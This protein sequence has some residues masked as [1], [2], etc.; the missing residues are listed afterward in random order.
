LSKVLVLGCNS[1]AGSVFVDSALTAG[2]DVVGIN[3]SG[4]GS[5]NFLPY[6][7][8]ARVKNYKFHQLHLVN[9]LEQ[10]ISVIGDCE[11]EYIVDFAGQGMVAESWEAP[12]LWYETNLVSKVRLHDFLRKCRF[13]KQYI[14]V[15]TPEVY[16]SNTGLISESCGYNPSTPYAVSHAAVDMSLLAFYRNYGFPAVITRFA[17]FYGPGQ[18]LY[19]IIPKTV[20]TALSSGV[21]NLHGGGS[22]IR[23]FI[24]ASDIASALLLTLQ[25]GEPGE[26]YHFTTDEFLTIREVVERIL[27]R[28]DID[29]DSCVKITS[30]RLGKDQAY[31]MD[32]SKAKKALGWQP[33]V[34][35]DRGVDSTISWVREGITE[36]MDLPHEYKHKS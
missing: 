29:F 35:F 26:V 27:R 8:N 5:M 10:I 13:L 11:P 25:K 23:A 30:D 18:Q 14:R 31:L 32:S 4:E 24:Y 2:F 33:L 7:R 19:R 21:L 12:E 28:L 17:N 22:S 20:L 16:G 3:R 15:S 34:S 1:F 6:K 36:F 9:N